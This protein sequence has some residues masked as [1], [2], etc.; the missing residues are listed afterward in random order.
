MAE[1]ELDEDVSEVLETDF[2]SFRTEWEGF[3]S[4]SDD[5]TSDKWWNEYV[6]WFIQQMA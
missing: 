5:T 1:N 3:L 6:N 4:P 2:L